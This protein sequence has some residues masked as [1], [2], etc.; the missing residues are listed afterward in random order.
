MNYEGEQNG[1][2]EDSCLKETKE[3]E[4]SSFC[5]HSK[6]IRGEAGGQLCEEREKEGAWILKR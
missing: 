6:I 1:S 3:K 5:L 2:Y 4:I